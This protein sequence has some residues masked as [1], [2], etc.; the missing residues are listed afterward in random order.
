MKKKATLT[1]A[2]LWLCIST[3]N[4]ATTFLEYNFDDLTL[5]NV[6]DW[7]PVA[8]TGGSGLNAYALT[9]SPATFT[10]VQSTLTDNPDDHALQFNYFHGNSR[11][12][13]TTQF[14]VSSTPATK[15][16]LLPTTFSTGVSSRIVVQIDTPV[17]WSDNDYYQYLS[18]Y[19]LSNNGNDLFGMKYTAA[20]GTSF[21]ANVTTS[22][23]LQT[24][25]VTQAD[26][27]S[28]LGYSI[29]GRST[30]YTM[31][32]DAATNNMELY[33]DGQSVGSM[34][35]TGTIALDAGYFYVGNENNTNWSRY[36]IYDDVKV[37]D[38]SLLSAEV[39]A[40]YNS[41]IP[42][43][44]VISLLIAGGTLGL[45]RKRK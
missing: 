35:T 24:L 26:I 25:R 42:E 5:G 38:G 22:A 30:V 41:L 11:V 17:S 12:N 27:E 3:G 36:G 8:D 15:W 20:G 43:P 10:C 31:S 6:P 16:E 9:T 18:R 19:R 44:T 37:W 39:M 14:T 34:T 1:I 33:V 4:A 40:D 7:T 13:N 28:Q 32:W 2:L 29:L 21:E 23:G 45:L